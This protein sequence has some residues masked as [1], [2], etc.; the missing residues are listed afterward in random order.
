MLLESF[1][2]QTNKEQDLLD[3]NSRGPDPIANRARESMK[4]HAINQKQQFNLAKALVF[5]TS[6]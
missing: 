4:K 5:S 6:F 2:F 3:V 1:P